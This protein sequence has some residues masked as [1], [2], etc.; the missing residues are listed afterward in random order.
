MPVRMEI[1]KF[2]PFVDSLPILRMF[3]QY[4]KT[5]YFRFANKEKEEPGHYVS[6]KKFYSVY[7][8]SM[9]SCE[10]L[11]S[12]RIFLEPFHVLFKVTTNLSL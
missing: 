6:Y 5:A 8:L 3:L 9:K 2:G 1:S 7:E 10:G 11:L 4:L 12:N